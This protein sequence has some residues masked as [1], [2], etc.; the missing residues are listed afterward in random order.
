LQ[1][2]QA[3]F[4]AFDAGDP[5]LSPAGKALWTGVVRL[6]LDQYVARGERG[7]EIALA[8]QVL[9]SVGTTTTTDPGSG[10]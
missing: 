9:D 4:V 7:D 10:S 6:I 3:C 8:R 1:P 2:L 5:H